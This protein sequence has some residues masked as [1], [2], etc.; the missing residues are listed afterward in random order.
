V[1]RWLASTISMGLL[2][3]L[4]WG[5]MPL[6]VS[7][8]PLIPA[9]L[10]PMSFFSFP[11]T[12]PADL[13]VQDGQ[14]TACPQSPNCVSSQSPTT[15]REHYI[16]PIVYAGSGPEALAKLR[17]LIAGLERTT[18]VESSDSYLCAE[19]ASRLMGFVDDVEF[20]VD[21]S[22]KVIHVRSASRLGQS[23]LG[24]N[25]QRIE[26]LRSQFA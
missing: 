6:T 24:V 18:I 26:D 1:K 10:S 5:F 14:L 22:A 12:R 11:G 23:D 17:T 4:C 9:L 15:D 13:G 2:I 25:R 7:A 8:Q 19:F 20:S 16:A 3:L 21:D